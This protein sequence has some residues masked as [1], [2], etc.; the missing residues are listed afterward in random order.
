MLVLFFA[1]T[2]SVFTTAVL[3]AILTIAILAFRR[4]LAISKWGRML[5]LLILIGTAASA[6]SAMRDSYGAEGALF[7]MDGMITLL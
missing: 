5:L 3:I 1:N 4:R 6:T 7:P 2:V